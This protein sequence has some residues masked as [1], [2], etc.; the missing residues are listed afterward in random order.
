MNSKYFPK[1][2]IKW[3]GSDAAERYGVFYALSLLDHPSAVLL[4]RPKKAAAGTTTLLSLSKEEINREKLSSRPC[5]G[6]NATFRQTY[7]MPYTSLNCDISHLQF[8]TKTC[9]LSEWFG[10]IDNSGLPMCTPEYLLNTPLAKKNANREQ[11]KCPFECQRT[12]YN[13]KSTSGGSDL[14]AIQRYLDS[15]NASFILPS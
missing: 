3:K 11:G 14:Q 5:M 13:I 4:K 6:D 1:L 9:S 10:I 8:L 15:R 2:D 12:E 7:G